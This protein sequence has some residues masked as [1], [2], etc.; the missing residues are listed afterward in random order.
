MRSLGIPLPPKGELDCRDVI[1]EKPCIVGAQPTG[2]CSEYNVAVGFFRFIFYISPY[3]LK[4]RA[5]N[6]FTVH[7]SDV[8]MGSLASAITSN[9]IV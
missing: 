4:V 5:S 6:N 9:T 3:I 7:Y 1:V 2:K 8:I